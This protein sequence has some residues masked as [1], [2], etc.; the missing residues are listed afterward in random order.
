MFDIIPKHIKTPAEVLIQ[1]LGLSLNISNPYIAAKERAKRSFLLARELH[2]S[3]AWIIWRGEFNKMSEA[4]KQ[5]RSIL[6][7]FLVLFAQ[8]L[9]YFKVFCWNPNSEEMNRH[10]FCLENSRTTF[11][12]RLT[13][14]VSQKLLSV[15]QDTTKKLRKYVYLIL[16]ELTLETT[17]KHP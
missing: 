10:F 2:S 17:I 9:F 13:G 7:M 4:W 16:G 8:I 12:Q 15:W 5:W 11:Y 3:E 1:H 6:Q 14:T